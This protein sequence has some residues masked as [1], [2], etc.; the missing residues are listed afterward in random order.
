MA[1]RGFLILVLMGTLSGCRSDSGSPTLPED[2]LSDLKQQI[3]D[4]YRQSLESGHQVPKDAL[5]WARQD[6][7]KIGDWEYR[8][9]DVEGSSAK[10]RQDRLNELGAERWEAFLDR[11]Y[12]G[13][14]PGSI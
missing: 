3:Q 1:K 10:V 8:I 2:R 5:E 11:S 13:W 12:S 4:L 6:L 9:V 14:N 7:L